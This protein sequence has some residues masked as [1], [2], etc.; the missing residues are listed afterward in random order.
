LHVVAGGLGSVHDLALF[1]STV[2]ELEELVA[3]KPNEPT[4][5]LA[6]K[7]YI[8]FTDPPILQLMTPY[9]KPRNGVLSQAQLA[10]NK[11]LDSALVIIENYFGRPSN[12]FLIMVR[13]WGFEEQFY[14]AIF[15][16]YCAL[17]NY[18]I[19]AGEGGSLRMQEGD[20]YG[21]MSTLICT[22]RKKAVEDARE[23]MKRRRSKRAA[24][25]DAQERIDRE[26]VIDPEE[27]EQ[28][29]FAAYSEI[30]GEE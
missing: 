4:K 27:D 6:D 24:V 30:S 23:R 17:A 20:E 10:A 8:G 5:L 1:R 26:A 29:V 18:D 15:K 2:T 19:L 16:I 22:K 13:R 14:P 28:R 7:G 25:G 21:V 9:K 12:R 3:S 11:K